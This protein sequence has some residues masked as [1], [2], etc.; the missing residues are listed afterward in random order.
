MYSSNV[1]LGFSLYLVNR[2]W[3][4]TINHRLT[5][6]SQALMSQPTGGHICTVLQQLVSPRRTALSVVIGNR[7]V[8]HRVSTNASDASIWAGDLLPGAGLR[9]AADVLTP[10]TMESIVKLR[11]LKPRGAW[12][13]IGHES[14][15]LTDAVADILRSVANRHSPHPQSDRGNV[16]TY[17]AFRSLGSADPIAGSGNGLGGRVFGAAA[18]ASHHTGDSPRSRCR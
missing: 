6:Q 17:H 4:R 3:L 8:N 18:V 7:A 9:F 5:V 11:W 12:P 10:L 13:S 2:K 1:F 16:R 14:S 15:E